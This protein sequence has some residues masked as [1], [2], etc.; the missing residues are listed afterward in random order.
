MMTQRH[1][2]ACSRCRRGVVR[3]NVCSVCGRLHGWKADS[4]R[5]TRQERGYDDAWL[6]LRAHHL[7]EH[8]LCV[9]CEGSGRVAIAVEVH[10]V[11]PFRG[12]D[13]PGRLDRLRAA[14]LHAS[15]RHVWPAWQLSV[16]AQVL[17]LRS[18][19][20]R[21]TAVFGLSSSPCPNFRG[22]RSWL[23]VPRRK[24]GCRAGACPAFVGRR[25]AP[26]A[27]Q[28]SAAARGPGR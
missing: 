5:G 21:M 2:T 27:P 8:P 25:A 9:D 22:S 11:R 1:G 12:V 13:D 7:A 24:P 26:R 15:S 19:S 16:I 28:T 14:R 17:A 18:L 10:H 4:E 20:L 23:L 3:G 6:R